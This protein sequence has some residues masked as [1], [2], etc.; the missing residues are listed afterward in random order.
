MKGVKQ[1]DHLNLD[2][3]TSLTD[4]V[5]IRPG[6]PAHNKRFWYERVGHI[7]PYL[8]NKDE[9]WKPL[10]WLSMGTAHNDAYFTLGAMD[11][12]Q[13]L[14]DAE[15]ELTVYL[16]TIDAIPIIDG[17]STEYGRS[18]PEV[19]CLISRRPGDVRL[20]DATGHIGSFQMWLEVVRSDHASSK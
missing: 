9:S 11:P 10:T 1:I 12:N 15:R 8:L 14:P 4:L 19:R 18:W 17:P 13:P 5:R 7:V 2:D 3:F 6:I 20:L 16:V